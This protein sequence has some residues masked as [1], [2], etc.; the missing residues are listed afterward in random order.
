[1]N[2]RFFG[3]ARNACIERSVLRGMC[4]PLEASVKDSIDF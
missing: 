3:E 2:V 1:M 4:V